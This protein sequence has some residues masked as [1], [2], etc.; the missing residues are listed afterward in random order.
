MMS[1]CFLDKSRQKRTTRSWSKA[2]SRNIRT[3]TMI[4]QLFW[5]F[6]VWACRSLLYLSQ[7]M[8]QCLFDFFVLSCV[9]SERTWCSSGWLFFGSFC[10][11]IFSIIGKAIVTKFIELKMAPNKSTFLCNEWLKCYF[12]SLK[13]DRSVVYY[14]FAL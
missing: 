7:T 4:H 13:K 3:T 1:S 5:T 10:F 6:Q 14:T 12:T 8:Q 9:H 2:A 11:C